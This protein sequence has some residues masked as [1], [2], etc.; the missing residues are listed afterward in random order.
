MSSD[1]P[2]LYPDSCPKDE[3]DPSY[4]ILQK[5]TSTSVSFNRNWQE[6]EDGFGDPIGDMWLGL[7][8]MYILCGT[9][10]VC[11]MYVFLMKM[12]WS[13]EWA[14]YYSVSVTDASDDYLLSVNHYTGDGADGLTTVN[15]IAFST[16][17]NDN[18]ETVGF[19]C[20]M[21]KGGGWW[22]NDCGVTNLNGL[23]GSTGVDA[24]MWNE[25][26][27]YRKV[28]IKIKFRA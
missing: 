4:I 21:S 7:K 20:A 28:V 6:Y 16:H 1:I 12:D 3:Y 5:R 22:Y 26:V 23:Y 2:I 13:T 27:D 17:D 15:G 18:D 9:P 19:N 14:H 24:I 11:E 10:K 8:R 25:N